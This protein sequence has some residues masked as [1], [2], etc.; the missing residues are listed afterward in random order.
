M[1]YPASILVGPYR[2]KVRAHVGLEEDCECI[3]EFSSSHQRIRLDAD[4]IKA[5]PVRMAE[6]F[7]HEILHAIIYSYYTLDCGDADKVEERVVS[8]LSTGLFKVLM[9][10][11]EVLQLLIEAVEKENGN[12]DNSRSA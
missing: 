3:G 11:P 12:K 9:D 8:N 10:N 1:K 4:Q 2:I 7:L 6:T 5:H